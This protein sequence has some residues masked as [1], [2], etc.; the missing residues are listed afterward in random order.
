MGTGLLELVATASFPLMEGVVFDIGGL[1]Q[2]ELKGER[3]LL[4]RKGRLKYKLQ[5]DFDFGFHL[6]IPI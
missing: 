3:Y 2:S 4:L 5:F 6:Q 1:S